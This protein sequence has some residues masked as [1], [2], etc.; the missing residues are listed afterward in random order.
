MKKGYT[1]ERY[2][3]DLL[4]S[5][6]IEVHNFHFIN[7]YAEYGFYN[8]KHLNTSFSSIGVWKIKYKN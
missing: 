4:K 1:I 3:F 7:L 5:K 8:D 2:G 6:Y